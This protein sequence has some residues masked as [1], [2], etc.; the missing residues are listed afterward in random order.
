LNSKQKFLVSFRPK[1]P[2]LVQRPDNYTEPIR[3]LKNCENRSQIA[4]GALHPESASLGMFG[5]KTVIP[6]VYRGFL[7]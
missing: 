7:S 4:I 6:T 1:A 3:W 5:C 2:K